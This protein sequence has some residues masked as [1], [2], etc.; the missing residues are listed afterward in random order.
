MNTNE[1][2]K[3]MSILEACFVIKSEID[4]IKIQ[5]EIESNSSEKIERYEV[6]LVLE[7]LENS[8][9]IT[10]LGSGF[11]KKYEIVEA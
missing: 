10:K 9:L 8:G 6:A 3:R 4:V 1:L 2:I 5:R 11:Y 7:S